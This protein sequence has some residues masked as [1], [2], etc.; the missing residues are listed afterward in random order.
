MRVYVRLSGPLRVVVGCEIELALNGASATVAQALESLF[1]RYPQA[2]RYLRTPA[3]EWPPGMR[4][5]VADV[6]L[7]DTTALVAPLHEDD[8]LT[9]LM[10]VVG[11]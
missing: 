8:H 2:R 6:R 4:A 5:L 10:P 9:L 7:D 11:G 3:G 1:V